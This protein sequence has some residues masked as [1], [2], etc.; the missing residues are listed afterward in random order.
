MKGLREP[1]ANHRQNEKGIKAYFSLKV[2]E[3]KRQ[4]TAGGY[5]AG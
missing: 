2:K 3:F 4:E 5:G 1:A